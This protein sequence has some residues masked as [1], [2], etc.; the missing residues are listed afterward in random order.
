MPTIRILLDVTKVQAQPDQLAAKTSV[1]IAHWRRADCDDQLRLSG[2]N[3]DLRLPDQ[4]QY[5]QANR[6][7]RLA[8]A[9]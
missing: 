6:S 7:R 5:R 1:G 9:A 8:T 2:C 4:H 3:A